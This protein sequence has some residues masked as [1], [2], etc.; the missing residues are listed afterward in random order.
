MGKNNKHNKPVNRELQYMKPASVGKT[1]SMVMGIVVHKSRLDSAPE[2]MSTRGVLLDIQEKYL[3]MLGGVNDDTSI[4]IAITL[5]PKDFK[6]PEG[7]K[8][9]AEDDTKSLSEGT[10]GDNS[11]QDGNG[12]QSIESQS[13]G[14]SE[15]TKGD[16]STGSEDDS[17]SQDEQLHTGD[18]TNTEETIPE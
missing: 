8:E 14:V 16:G 7:E 17:G 6:F 2:A 13:T 18:D 11:E 12:S 10:S 15:E 9:N 3:Q 1:E 4:A 5:V